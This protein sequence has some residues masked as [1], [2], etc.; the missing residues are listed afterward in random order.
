MAFF[1]S[2]GGQHG[3]K[4]SVF[5][6]S[7]LEGDFEMRVLHEIDSLTYIVGQKQLYQIK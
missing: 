7:S 5:K 2:R 6:I 3:V 4:K 1:T